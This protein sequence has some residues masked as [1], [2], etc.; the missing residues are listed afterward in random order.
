MIMANKN[1][2][3][4]YQDEVNDDF[5][6]AKTNLNIVLDEN[7]QYLI[8]NPIRKFISFIIYYFIALPILFVEGKVFRG[9]IIKG[10]QNLKSIKKKGYI[11][12]A[13]HTDFRD[14]YLGHVFIANPKRTYIIANKDAVSIF[15]VRRLTKDLGALPVPD[16][17]GGLKKLNAS[18]AQILDDKKA[19]MVYPEAHIWPYYTKVRPFPVTSFRYAAINNVPCVPV[20]ATYRKH[21]GLF[22]FRKKPQ[23]VVYIGMPIFPNL[24]LSVKENATNLRDETHAYISQMTE[25]YSTYEYYKYIKKE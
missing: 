8:T 25:K 3:M 1:R 13:N 19:L 10:K 24:E 18:V 4:Y 20:A 15:L 5:V 2:V 17:Y 14:A 21:K 11:M 23:M 22:F 6:K 7:Y 9:L 12:Y 16:T